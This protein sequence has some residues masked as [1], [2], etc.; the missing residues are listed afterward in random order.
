MLVSSNRRMFS[1]TLALN[2]FKAFVFY[3]WTSFTNMNIL[4][5]SLINRVLVI[6]LIGIPLLYLLLLLSW[7][8][9]HNH[10]NLIYFFNCAVVIHIF[11]C[12]KCLLWSSR[13]V[14]TDKVH[15]S[16]TAIV[17]QP[18]IGFNR[19]NIILSLLGLFLHTFLY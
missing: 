18:T 12:L 6:N 14:A 1:L 19:F 16:S 17:S 2:L 8:I 11:M 5:P 4:G 10:C 3:S 13:N 7:L 9:S 15:L